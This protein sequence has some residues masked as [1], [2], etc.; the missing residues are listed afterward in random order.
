MM[1]SFY[2]LA[3]VA[4]YSLLNFLSI[5]VFL[6]LFFLFFCFFFFL[7]IYDIHCAQKLI[8]RF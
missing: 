8:L 3:E 2:R 5:F 6:L 7:F 1:L 4:I